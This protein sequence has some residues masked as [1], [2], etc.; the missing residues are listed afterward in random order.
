MRRRRKALG[1]LPDSCQIKSS[2]LPRERKRKQSQCTCLYKQFAGYHAGQR[3]AGSAREE[4]K[5][6]DEEMRSRHS[7]N[8]PVARPRCTCSLRQEKF[9]GAQCR[10]ATG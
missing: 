5:P 9:E 6:H 10:A 7:G 1:V 8:D 2:G 4:V 3:N